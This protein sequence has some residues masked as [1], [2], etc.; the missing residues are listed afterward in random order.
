MK[1]VLFGLLALGLTTQSYSQIIK[2]E[3]LSEVVVVATNF[4][5]LNDVNSEEVASIPV[6][7]LQRKVAAY[8]V[9]DSEFYQDEYGVYN[10]TFYIPQGKI[11]AEYN[12]EGKIVRTIERFKDINLPM[13]VK[14]AVLDKYPKWTITKDI[15]MVSYTDN[16]GSKKT[17][18]LKLE[19]G[20]ET[21]RVKTDGNG[22]FL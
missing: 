1:K 13:S 11:L 21:I 4:K 3:E 6:E 20:G 14:K 2:T 12:G 17:Y 18:K 10:I 8:D 7:L 9:K 16:S 22:N 19:N 15:Y 5:Y